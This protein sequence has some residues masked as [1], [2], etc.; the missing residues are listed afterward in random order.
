MK[1]SDIVTF[2]TDQWL[3]ILH[4]VDKAEVADIYDDVYEKMDRLLEMVENK[5]MLPSA[6][7]EYYSNMEGKK[8][9]TGFIARWDAE[10]DDDEG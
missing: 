5:G 1:R 7:T 3:G 10:D 9:G 4:Q 6:H 2:M 8:L